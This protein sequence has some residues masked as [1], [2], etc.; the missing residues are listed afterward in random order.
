MDYIYIGRVANTHG[1]RGG[2]KIFPT[3]D[4]PQRFKKLKKVTLED[5]K[6]RDKDYK[7]IG[8]KYSGQ[9]VVLQLE[10]VNDMDQAMLL[11]QSI[12]KIPKKQALPLDKDEYYIQDLYGLEILDEDGQKIGVLRD[13]IF[14]GSN[15]VYIIDLDDERELLLPAIKECV[16]DVNIKKGTMTIHIME[17][18]L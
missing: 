3:T 18:L 13:I 7:I 8:I 16:L 5:L 1:V 17:G 15:E 9:F 14:T 10:G 4:D 12:V 6:G 2:L 11:K